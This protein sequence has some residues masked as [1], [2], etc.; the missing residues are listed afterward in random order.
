MDYSNLRKHLKTMKKSDVI[1]LLIL[2]K[3]ELKT[4]LEGGD[5]NGRK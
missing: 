4:H 3:M 5:S 1:E 2:L